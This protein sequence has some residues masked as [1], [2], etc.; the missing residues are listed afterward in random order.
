MRILS[1]LAALIFLLSCSGAGKIQD[2]KQRLNGSWAVVSLGD[3]E[4]SV[5]I[6]DDATALPQLEIK[7]GEMSYKGS[8]GCNRLMGGLIELDEKNIRFGVAAGTQMMCPDMEIPD[9]FNRSLSEVRSWEIRKNQLHLFN[10]QGE[11]L[12]QLKKID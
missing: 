8:D 10:E 12:M 5:T 9:L 7:V 3:K 4:L 11:E 1:S 6:G 2:E